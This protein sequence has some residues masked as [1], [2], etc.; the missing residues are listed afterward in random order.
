MACNS[1]RAAMFAIAIGAC[2]L[3]TLS[4]A[5]SAVLLDPGSRTGLVRVD[6]GVE[7]MRQQPGSS[8]GVDGD[9]FAWV[10]TR[11]G[12]FSVGVVRDDQPL[13]QYKVK[14]HVLL[15]KINPSEW[16]VVLDNRDEV[17]FGTFQQGIGYCLSSI[18]ISTGTQTDIPLQHLR[19]VPYLIKMP[20][21]FGIYSQISKRLA[22]FSP[23]DSS[24]R[25]IFEGIPRASYDCPPR[26]YQFVYVPDAGVVSVE[27]GRNFCSIKRETDEYLSPVPPNQPGRR[28]DDGRAVA[29]QPIQLQEG[30]SLLIALASEGERT[31]SKFIISK[32]ATGEK[33]WEYDPPFA[34]SGRF[35]TLADPARIILVNDVAH[36][37][38]ELDVESRTLRSLMSL[39]DTIGTGSSL[40]SFSP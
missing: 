29:Y 34:T 16:L 20:Q 28:Y 39:P 24:F 10:A 38:V 4:F 11:D 9:T 5:Q 31:I 27:N 14:G 8:Y 17:Y 15:P 7:T 36:E 21:G 19:L 23:G 32:V 25:V 6:A 1:S 33:L 26:A 22:L 35:L 12:G 3:T 2:G 18:N 37:L 40:L 30:A 13:I